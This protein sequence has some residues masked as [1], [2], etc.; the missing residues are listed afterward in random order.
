MKSVLLLIAF[1][2]LYLE[3]EIIIAVG[4]LLGALPL[5]LL[6]LLS[7][8]VGILMIKSRGA[9]FLFNARSQIMSGQF[10][11][12]S[13]I[14]S[15]C[16]VAAGILF[17]IPGLLS[18]LIA[19]LLLLPPVQFML[20]NGLQRKVMDWQK[21]FFENNRTFSQHFEQ[22]QEKPGDV[23]DAEFEHRVDEDKRLK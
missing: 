16:W 15:A 12:N 2:F 17:L 3:L 10:P 4:A 18:D 11:I 19:I 13:A 20:S 7:A 9:M 22:T 1:V 21:N 14:S 5:I 23:F 8:C 6:L